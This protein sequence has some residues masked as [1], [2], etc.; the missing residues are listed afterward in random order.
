MVNKNWLVTRIIQISFFR[1]CQNKEIIQILN[2]W[3]IKALKQIFVVIH[4]LQAHVLIVHHLNGQIYI[5]QIGKWTIVMSLSTLQKMSYISFVLFCS[6]QVLQLIG[7][8]WSC[9]VNEKIR[10]KQV[11]VEN[12][13]K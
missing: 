9:F 7:P 10:I 13:Q 11:Y 8:Y 5:G 6:Q 12:K 1:V 2:S 4:S 3:T